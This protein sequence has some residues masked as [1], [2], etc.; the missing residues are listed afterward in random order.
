[1]SPDPA[2][3][4]AGLRALPPL[5]SALIAV[6]A[7]LPVLGA[8]FVWDDPVLL[9]TAA[10]FGRWVDIWQALSQGQMY[11][12]GYF[13]PLGLAMLGFEQTLSGGSTVLPHAVNLALHVLNAA[14]V[15]WIGTI[16]AAARGLDARRSTFA[17]LLAGAIYAVHPAVTETV[18]WVSC[19]FDLL[20]TFFSLLLLAVDRAPLR[21]LPRAALGAALFLLAALS[22]EMAATLPLLLPFWHL[23]FIPP[24]AGPRE[25]W[26]LY[27]ERGH[28]LQYLWLAAAAG[29]YLAL[30]MASMQVLY[31]AHAGSPSGLDQK[32]LLVLETLGTYAGVIAW[33]FANLAPFHILHA[34]PGWS[35][36]P[37]L[38]AL[39]AL[40]LCVGLLWRRRAAGCLALCGL[41]AMLP[42]LNIVPLPMGEI[43]ASERLIYLPL[44]FFALLAAVPLAAQLQ[45]RW[46][47][48]AAAFV[49]FWLAASLAWVR[50]TAAHWHDNVS[51]WSWAYKYEPRSEMVVSNVLFALRGVGMYQELIDFAAQIEQQSGGL[52]VPQSLQV[53]NAQ[54]RLGTR[55]ADRAV[56]VVAVLDARP[57]H[58][59][60]ESRARALQYAD[61]GWLLID[62]GE[63][64]AAESTF[65]KA[66]ADDPRQGIAVLGLAVVR[67]AREGG[68]MDASGQALITPGDRAGWSRRGERILSELRAGH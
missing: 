64:A 7:F 29:L 60:S 63:V 49:L 24:S 32:L 3:P 23:Q 5:L 57:L 15:A 20:C 33:P 2:V 56:Q 52:T 34:A 51:F 39:A 38:A 44:V 14:A 36:A 30:R 61:L 4:A 26:R 22:K 11:L 17:G 28:V 40:A 59:T 8:G 50:S 53:L 65:D 54:L 21:P 19:R 1:M 10:G 45:G 6:L 35:D 67:A 13:R 41:I 9:S 66:L 16:I 68:Q 12:F 55:V 37:V 58:D 43:Y 48:I 62:D 31:F 27:R 47:S 18:A 25:L 42:V 46:R